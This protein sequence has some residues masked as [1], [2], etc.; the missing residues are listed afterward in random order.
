[1]TLDL[2]ILR[3]VSLFAYFTMASV[4]MSLFVLIAAYKGKKLVDWMLMI[5]DLLLEILAVRLFLLDSLR[6][7]LGVGF[8]T[9]HWVSLSV[10][11]ITLFISLVREHAMYRKKYL[12]E[13]NEKAEE[14]HEE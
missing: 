13:K 3:V 7:N 6:I 1:M 10:V 12:L 8:I 2:E 11:C 9:I 4:S 5:R 14:T